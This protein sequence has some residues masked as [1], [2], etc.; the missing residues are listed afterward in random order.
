MSLYEFVRE[1]PKVEIHVH[2]EGSIR[3]ATLLTLAERNGVDLPAHDLAGLRDFYR[4]TSF[5]HFIHV[6]ITIS[7]CL[8]TAADYCLIAYEFGAEMARQHVRYAEVT[9]SPHTNV[10]NSG[11]AFGQILAALNEGRRQAGAEFGVEFRWVLDIVRD[12]VESRHQVAEWAV[13][14]ADRGV[15]GFGLGGTENDYP[16]QDYADAFARARAAGLHSVPHAGEVAGPE[17]IW[18]AIWALNADRIGH[19]VRCIEDP[20]LVDYLRE[21]Q[22]PLELCPTSNLCLGV[23][24]SYAE[25][26]IRRLWEQGV[27]VTVNSDDPPMFN[28]DLVQ[29]YRH[30]ADE[31]GFT[32]AELEQLS[33]N[34]LGASFLPEGQKAALE[35]EFRTDFARLRDKH[36][37]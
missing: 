16:P 30:L 37:A 18:G 12:D 25:H 4:F 15:V 23:Y 26:P 13:Q 19:G 6:Y 36:L 8:Q 1:M 32:A 22:I 14:G 24:S 35:S 21:H 28:T 11:L 7:R 10:Q 5:P 3:P 29:E 33:L 31:L 2:L 27:Y 17:S 20:A 9:F 34:A